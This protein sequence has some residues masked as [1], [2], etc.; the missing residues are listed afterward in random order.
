V[1]ACAL[2]AERKQPTLVLTHSEPLLEQWRSQLQTPLGLPSKQVGQL[3]GGRRKRTASIASST[4]VFLLA[5][6]STRPREDDAVVSYHP[7]P[8]RSR[9]ALAYGSRGSGRSRHRSMIP[10]IDGSSCG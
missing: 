6:F 10:V 9:S 7:G 2:I 1:I 8:R 5:E 4:T 3:G